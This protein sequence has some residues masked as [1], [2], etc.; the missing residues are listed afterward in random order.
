M[1]ELNPEYKDQEWETTR[2]L[3]FAVKDAFP[4]S[5]D[6]DDLLEL[7][8][9]SSHIKKKDYKALKKQSQEVKRSL[10]W[11]KFW[12]TAKSPPLLTSEQLLSLFQS[13]TSEMNKIFYRLMFSLC[14][15]LESQSGTIYYI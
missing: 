12:G 11:G 8:H 6:P 3:L 10:L 15:K 14:E 2:K 9:A 1:S 7:L 13:S 5:T 4:S